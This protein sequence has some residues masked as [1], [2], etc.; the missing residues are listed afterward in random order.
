MPTS[1]KD[2]HGEEPK[3]AQTLQDIDLTMA[4]K[5]AGQ[6][7]FSSDASSVEDDDTRVATLARTLTRETTH[8]QGVNPFLDKRPE[9]D[10]NSPQFNARKWAKTLLHAFAQEPDKFPRP[11]VGVSWR[12]LCVHGFGKDT[13]YQKDILNVLWRA[14]LIARE[15]I[16]SRQQKIQILDH[17]DGLVKSGEMVLVLGRP[18]R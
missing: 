10:P 9:L 17:F 18:G 11:P 16:S 6:T 3:V 8:F 1:G 13:D 7:S 12:N 15:W 14:P 5:G 2:S 4:E